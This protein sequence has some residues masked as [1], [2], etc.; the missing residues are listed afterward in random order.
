MILARMEEFE[1][2]LNQQAEEN[3]RLTRKLRNQVANS[4]NSKKEKR[5]PSAPVAISHNDEQVDPQISAAYPRSCQEI[6]D[7]NPN[8]YY[9]NWYQ[10]IDPDGPGVGEP[11]INVL[12]GPNGNNTI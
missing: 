2:S 7:L 3:A 9:Y 12:C 10:W 1:T 11:P 5:Q 4:V 8:D 6:Y